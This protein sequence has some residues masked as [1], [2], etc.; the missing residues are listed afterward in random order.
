VVARN[1]WKVISFSVGLEVGNNFESTVML[2]LCN[3]KFDI[4]NIFTSVVC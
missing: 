2:W 4:A 1:A 3:K